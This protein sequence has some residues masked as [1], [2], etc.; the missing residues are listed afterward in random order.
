VRLL[1]KIGGAQLEEPAARQELAASVAGARR[2]GHEVV[3]VH[4]GGNQIRAL[5]KRL[6]IADRYHDGLRITDPATAEVVLMVL[7]GLVNRTLVAE[8]ERAGVRAVGLSGAD[9]GTFSARR[10]TRTGVDLG[11][12]GEVDRIDPSCVSL[13]C[14]AGIVPVLAT[15][16]PGPGSGE[17]FY[18][19]NA[20]HA[21]A[22]LARALGTDV[23]LFLTDVPGVLDRDGR[24]LPELSAPECERLRRDGVIAGGMIPK[25]DAA[26]AA[27]AASPSSVVKI[28]PAGVPDAI[29][30][31]LGPRSGTR[32]TAA[33]GA[34]HG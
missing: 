4:G 10:L 19:I 8:L 25:T 20:D 13:L 9:G 7:G 2:D 15:V 12:V 21:A 17:H 14:R 24:L 11:L 26:V 27:A 16:A 33:A 32:F 6:G 5:T 34:P 28:A 29:R 3:L 31:A 30:T 18:N 23:V 22:P 1:V